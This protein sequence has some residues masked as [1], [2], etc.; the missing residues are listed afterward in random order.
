MLLKR[1]AK[2]M[3]RQRLVAL[4]NH[5]SLEMVVV[6]SILRELVTTRRLEIV[7]ALAISS[8]IGVIPQ[9]APGNSFNTNVNFTLG[10]RYD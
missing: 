2:T 4:E 5:E 8:P 1:G 3:H 7:A 10:Q 9:V 6:P